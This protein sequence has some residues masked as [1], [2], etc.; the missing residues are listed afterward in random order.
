[1]TAAAA[2]MQTLLAGAVERTV[3]DE[4]DGRSGSTLERV[5]LAD[6]TI[7]V[8]KRSHPESDLTALVAGG[9]DRELVLLES[10]VLDRLP[11]GVG[12]ALVG[13]W[14]EGPDILLMMRDVAAA[15]PGWERV[16]DRAECRRVLAAAA[17][18][19]RAFT[20]KPVGG[21]CPA[22][23]RAMALWPHRMRPLACGANPLPGLVLRGWERFADLVPPGVAAA[24]A[25]LQDDPAPLLAALDRR[26]ASLLHGDLWLVNLGLE[27]G[28]VTLLDWSLATWGPPLMEF[29]TFLTGAFSQVAATPDEI[30]EDVVAAAGLDTP[31]KDLMLLLGLM[32]LG[33]NKALDAAEHTDEAKRARD[34]AELDWWVRAAT[35]ALQALCPGQTGVGLG[36]KW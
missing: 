27:P 28:Q 34:R 2:D 18:V 11:A 15:I 24:V 5:R 35:P 23:V 13:G 9:A 25:R 8:L 30:V 36:Q 22:A 32:E 7:L 33:W 31:D 21:L 1:M 4:H 6:G 29:A 3:I 19:H 14:R 10:G 16:L 12:H 20:A 26:P 17:G